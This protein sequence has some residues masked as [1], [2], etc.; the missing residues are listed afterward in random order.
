MTETGNVIRPKDPL[1]RDEKVRIESFCSGHDLS[2]MAS[3]LSGIFGIRAT[4]DADVIAGYAEDSSHLAGRA[5]VPPPGRAGTG[6]AARHQPDR[7]RG[8]H[9]GRLH[10]PGFVLDEVS[11]AG[12]GEPQRVPPPL[13]RWRATH[14]GLL[15]VHGGAGRA[16][17]TGRCRNRGE[18]FGHGARLASSA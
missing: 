3:F 13:F 1:T 6:S 5:S 17:P 4:D 18:A 11:R 12:R 2:A 10:Q 9:D 7:H 16:L 8:L 14:P 15:S